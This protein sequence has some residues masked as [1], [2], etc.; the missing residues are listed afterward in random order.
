MCFNKNSPEQKTTTATK[1]I[2]VY[3]IVYA[4]D[5]NAEGFK[6]A[7]QDYEYNFG[8][9][10]KSKLE[11][12][13]GYQ[14]ID[15]GIH[16]FANV[17][18]IGDTALGRKFGYTEYDDSYVDGIIIECIIP[19][20]SKYVFNNTDYVSN[21]LKPK[22]IIMPSKAYIENMFADANIFF[23]SLIKKHYNVK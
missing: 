18:Y 14:S 15:I 12:K 5:L 13:R 23:K 11:N 22:S 2:V 6:S 10:H 19:K 1:D 4:T 17:T 20:G 7:Y 3:K 8:R 9:L 16:S 21:Q